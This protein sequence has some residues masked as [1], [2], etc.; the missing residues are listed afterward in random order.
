MQCESCSE[1]VQKHMERCSQNSR[2]NFTNHFY[3]ERRQRR[4]LATKQHGGRL[5][6]D[7][8]TTEVLGLHANSSE[9][10][11]MLVAERGHTSKHLKCQ[12]LAISPYSSVSSHSATTFL[13]CSAEL[14][15]ILLKHLLIHYSGYTFFLVSARPHTSPRSRALIS[16]PNF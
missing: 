6:D 15:F 8:K 10:S 14:A 9:N 13:W 3:T 11:G 16:A 4:V 2:I 5:D 12:G 1:I 7:I